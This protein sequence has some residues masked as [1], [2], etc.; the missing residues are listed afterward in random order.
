MFWPP[1][2]CARMAVS[3][4]SSSGMDTLDEILSIWKKCLAGYQR[5]NF[6]NAVNLT[7]KNMFLKN[8]VQKINLNGIN[9]WHSASSLGTAEN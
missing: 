7:E 5:V 4:T 9:A 2:P 1:A 8:N 3:S 6:L